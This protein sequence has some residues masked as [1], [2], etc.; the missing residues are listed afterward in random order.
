M[1]QAIFLKKEQRQ[2][3]TDLHFDYCGISKNARLSRF[4]TC[5]SAKLYTA[6]RNG[7]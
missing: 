2:L 5:D 1:E 6:Y 3:K 7:G 4:W